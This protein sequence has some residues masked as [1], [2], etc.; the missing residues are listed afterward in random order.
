VQVAAEQVA[1]GST[2][3]MTRTEATA[4]GLRD[5]AMCLDQ[6]GIIVQHSTEAS[7]EA[8]AMSGT[9][10]GMA[11]KGNALV[12][13]VV[14]NMG[15][16]E[17]ASKRIH[18]I[19]GVIDGIAFQTNILALN[20][21]VEA[22][23][24][25]EQGR[26]FAVVAS[27]V[28]SLAQRSAAAAREIKELVS[29]SVSTVATGTRLVGGAGE[30]MNELVKSVTRVGELFAS[31]TQDTAEQM[32]GLRT[33]SESIGELGGITQQNVAVAEGASAA[34]AELRAQVARLGD[35]LSAFN[36]GGGPAPLRDAGAG[37]AAAAAAPRGVPEAARSARSAARAEDTGGATATR[38]V[39][40]G[41]V[42]FF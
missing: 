40:Q 33:V 21:A 8:R 32:A 2:E 7:S 41:E 30:N 35:V 28:R 42:E 16:I 12:S 14:R 23:R 38:S 10:A 11:D 36:L 9:A 26:G 3:L 15:S 22:A 34:A 31:V 17:S 25:G 39:A 18:D 24:A 6:I 5:S 13:E 20:A 27:E 29:V 37:A 4:S 19:I 1:T